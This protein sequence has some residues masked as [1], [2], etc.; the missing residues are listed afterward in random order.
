MVLGTADQAGRPWVSPVYFAAS[1]LS[2]FFWVSS[3]EATHSRNLARRPEVAIAICDSQV[4]IGAAQALYVTAVAEEVTG[5]ERE[6]GI[7]VFSDR[8]RSHGANRWGLEDV[9]L[10]A[11]HR[12]YRATA[13]A[14]WVLGE[15]DRRVPVRL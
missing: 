14:H 13:E 6:L 3:P 9:Q 1:E 8:S 11:R 2:Q 4:P 10:P 15:G 12:L 7:A 5:S